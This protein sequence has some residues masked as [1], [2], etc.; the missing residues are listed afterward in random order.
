MM[1]ICAVETILIGKGE[2]KL[3][4]LAVTREN[5]YR[6]TPEGTFLYRLD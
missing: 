4:K 3:M 6:K 1:L 5:K 2:R